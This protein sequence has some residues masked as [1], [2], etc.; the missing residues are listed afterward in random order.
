MARTTARKTPARKKPARR[1]KRPAKKKRS[2]N[3]AKLVTVIGLLL[4]LVVSMGAVGY[5]IFFRTV[6]V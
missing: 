6:V 4:L 5:V 1:K 3:V 2:L